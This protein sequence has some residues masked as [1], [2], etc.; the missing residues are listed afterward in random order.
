MDQ[1]NEK[2]FE[3]SERLKLEN[4]ELKEAKIRLAH[5]VDGLTERLAKIESSE[6][7]VYS[8]NVNEIKLIEY[9]RGALQISSTKRLNQLKLKRTSLRVGEILQHHHWSIE[10]RIKNLAWRLRVGDRL[11]RC[12]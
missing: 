6:G 12:R 8:G 7:E 11:R 5:Q 3:E 2:L 10:K 9:R 1:E 4:Q